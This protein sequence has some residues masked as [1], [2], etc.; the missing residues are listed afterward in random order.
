MYICVRVYRSHSYYT[1]PMQNCW[2]TSFFTGTMLVKTPFSVIYLNQSDKTY[3]SGIYTYFTPVLQSRNISRRHHHHQYFALDPWIINRKQ[4]VQF[5]VKTFNK[6]RHNSLD[7][8][9]CLT[10]SFPM[11]FTTVV[12]WVPNNCILVSDLAKFIKHQLKKYL[13]SVRL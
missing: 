10:W 12:D 11:T 2:K 6:S 3:L 5:L 8:D 7:V 4:Q 9:H 13:N 1:D